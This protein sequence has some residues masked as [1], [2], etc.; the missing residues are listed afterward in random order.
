MQGLLR[1]DVCGS[2][3][4]EL[5]QLYL[6]DLSVLLSLKVRRSLYVLLAIL[7]LFFFYTWSTNYL[8]LEYEVIGLTNSLVRYVEIDSRRRPRRAKQLRRQS[9]QSLC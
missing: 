3:F 7:L 6:D 8:P 4:M 5:T 9:L 2:V 1:G